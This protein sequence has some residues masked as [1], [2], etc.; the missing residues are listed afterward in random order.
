M[1]A[2]D[3]VFTPYIRT[4]RIMFA[5]V[6]CVFVSLCVFACWYACVIVCVCASLDLG[7]FIVQVFFVLCLASLRPP[8]RPT[9]LFVIA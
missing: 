8:A 7:T 1:V 9:F 2:N 6:L 5:C 3:D 4:K